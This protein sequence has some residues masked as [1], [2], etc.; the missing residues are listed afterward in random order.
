MP[1]ISDFR[2]TLGGGVRA[3]L[4]NA[5]INYPNGVG[6]ESGT[7]DPNVHLMIKG[8]QL[9]GSTIGNIQVPFRGRFTPVT[10]D[11][12]FP[13]VSI[14]ILNDLGFRHRKALEGWHNVI[15]G[16]IDNIGSENIADMYGEMI[17]EQLDREEK[18]LRTYNFF[19]IFPSD[20][21]PVDLSIDS[22]DT[23]SE[24][25]VTFAVTTWDTKEG[26]SNASSGI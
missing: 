1:K 2:A 24:Y 23:L 9:P 11:R 18:V 22:A 25:T 17:I 13:E 15:A 6:A 7:N 8:V 14:T 19:G 4:F 20:I 26:I 12:I 3:N 16:N 21:A 10:G 5:I